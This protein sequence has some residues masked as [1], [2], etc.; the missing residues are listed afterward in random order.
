MPNDLA[1]A[2]AESVFSKC[3]IPQATRKYYA[4]ILEVVQPHLEN[5]TRQHAD[6]V[7]EVREDFN[8]RMDRVMRVRHREAERIAD[9]EAE[10]KRLREALQREKAEIGFGCPLDKRAADRLAL[11]CAKAIQDGWL[12]TRTTI[13]DALLDYLKIGQPDGESDVPSWVEKQ[14]NPDAE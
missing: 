12:G 11:A 8:A 3:F 10:N 4:D 1:A 5:L 13:D 2:I 6:E 7:A 9:L 14:E